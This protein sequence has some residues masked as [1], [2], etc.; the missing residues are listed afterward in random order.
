MENESERDAALLSRL[1]YW[2]NGDIDA[3]ISCFLQSPFAQNKDEEHKRKLERP[4]YLERT[5]QNVMPVTT[6]QKENE[7]YQQRYI[8][9]SSSIA[10]NSL[11]ERINRIKPITAYTWDDKGMGEL[12]AD[13]Y[14]NECRYNVTAKEWYVYNGRVW[15]ADTGGMQVS[16]RAKELANA[17][18][19]YCTTIQNE[20]QKTDYLKIVM[21]YGTLRYRE[22]MLKDAR[23]KFYITQTDLD[24]NLD[25]F[26]CQNGTYN[27][28]TGEFSP[29]RAENLLS[30]CSNVI[31]DPTARSP[32]FEQF[33]FDVMQGN[34]EKINYLQTIFGYALTAETN[35]ETCWILYGATTR[36]GKST[37]V[38][39][40]AYMLGN[41]NGYAL[42]MQPQTLAQKQNKDTRQA[43][44]DIARLDG[45]RFLN[46]SEPPKRMLFDVAL[47]KTL[48]GRDSI[49][50]RHLYER[51]YEFIPHFKLFINTNFLP[52]IQD[53]TLF[54]SG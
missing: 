23:D 25:L 27:L 54:S 33:I 18:L 34:Q 48:L 5:A 45:C 36:N 37:L 49:T 14:R 31:Y 3:A 29:H 21:N 2:C 51:E 35:L 43:S 46:A 16:Q 42:A 26:N 1:L 19:V 38:E 41:S 40:I 12:F 52:L 30:K 7:T 15:Q 32:I 10:E 22:T 11:Q 47:L 8:R 39:T 24:R 9:Y 28:K 50:A 6:A 44:G 4:D 53:D 17:L 20:R 13:I